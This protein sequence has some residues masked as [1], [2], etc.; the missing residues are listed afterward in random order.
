MVFADA[1]ILIDEIRKQNYRP[2]DWE[3]DF[4]QSIETGRAR[5]LTPKQSKAL[6]GIYEKAVGAGIYAKDK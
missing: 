6:E 4:M 1:L 2:T 5:D 3:K